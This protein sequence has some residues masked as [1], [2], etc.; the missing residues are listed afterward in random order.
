MEELE[1]D[2]L[3][4]T[5][6]YLKSKGNIRVYKQLKTMLVIDLIYKNEQPR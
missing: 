2:I 6:K 5:H 3:Y 1:R 4:F